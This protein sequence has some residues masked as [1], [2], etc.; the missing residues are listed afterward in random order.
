MVYMKFTNLIK[1]ALKSAAIV[2]VG[3]LSWAYINEEYYC[4]VSEENIKNKEEAVEIIKRNIRWF[5]SGKAT[6]I[7]QL[8]NFKN[9]K[10]TNLVHSGNGWG[11]WE[12]EDSKPH[13]RRFFV[14]YSPFDPIDHTFECKVAC[15]TIYTDQCLTL[16]DSRINLD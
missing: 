6:R 15:G 5:T 9:P 1:I 12:T 8:E 2:A 16:R 10:I 7:E 3:V 14:S 13:K 4:K 11:A